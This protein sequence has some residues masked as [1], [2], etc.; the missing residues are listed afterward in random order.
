M[1]INLLNKSI[2]LNNVQI[3]E[4]L[5]S[6]DTRN[7][8]IN[9]YKYLNLENSLYRTF[10][11]D[12]IFKNDK[13]LVSDVIDL[14]IKINYFSESLYKEIKSKLSQRSNY[15]VKL[16]S[17]DFI[18]HFYFFSKKIKNE[19]ID[20]NLL[21]KNKSSNRIVKFQTFINLLL[22][23]E[24]YYQKQILNNLSKNDSP[25]Y[26]YRLLNTILEYKHFDFVLEN[27]FFKTKLIALIQENK[28]I[29]IRDKKEFL[30]SL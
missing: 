26:I 14:A 1:D 6:E 16:S 4:Y 29:N 27:S 3:T 11:E 19:Y 13:Y 10:I 22:E 21:V 9:N 20:I 17:L 5:Y 2:K 12:N 7:Y 24:R 30:E 15:L 28:I 18:N 25:F 23:N 8:F